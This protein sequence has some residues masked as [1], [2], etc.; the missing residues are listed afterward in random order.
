[1]L[2]SMRTQHKLDRL[3]QDRTSI[4]DQSRLYVTMTRPA[5]DS[6]CLGDYSLP[7]SASS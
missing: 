2:M 1:M 4:E 5:R 7:P 3:T 6:T